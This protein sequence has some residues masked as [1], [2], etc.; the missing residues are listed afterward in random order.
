MRNPAVRRIER[1]GLDQREVGEYVFAT[2]GEASEAAVASVHRETEGNPLFMAELL[3][4]LLAE[5]RLEEITAAGDNRRI[6]VPQGVREVILRR[7]ALLSEG[8]ASVLS[9]ASV[10][11]REFEVDVLDRV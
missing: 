6:S 10:L 4:L 5:G 7:V 1:R 8:C 9:T 2:A 11:G 3:R